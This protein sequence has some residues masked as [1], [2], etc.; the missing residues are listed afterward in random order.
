MKLVVIETTAIAYVAL[1]ICRVFHHDRG[2]VLPALFIAINPYGG[3]KGREI[4]RRRQRVNRC[5]NVTVGIKQLS[6]LRKY[7]RYGAG[8]C[9]QSMLLVLSKNTV[10]F[11]QILIASPGQDEQY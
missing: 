6:L 2:H 3:G 9:R 11:L 1:I 4:D 10:H 7:S 5:V 8:A